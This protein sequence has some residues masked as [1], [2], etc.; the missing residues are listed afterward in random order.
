M[1]D[2]ERDLCCCEYYDLTNNRN[3]ILA[4][5]CNCTDLDEAVDSFLKGQTIAE[6]NK[7]RFQNTM[8]DRLRIPWIG[9][10]RQVAFDSVLPL[11]ILPLMLLTAS[12]SLWW[13][14]FSFSTVGMFLLL[15][16]NFFIKT[17]PRTKFFFVW[18]ITSI[19]LLYFIFEF[20]VIPFLKILIEENVIL[21]VLIFAFI[22]CLYLTKSR[23]DQLTSLSE[24]ESDLILNGKNIE[25][26]YSCK[27]C[28]HRIPDKDHHCVWFDCCITNHNQCS[29]LLS[30]IFAILALLY[31]S[32]LTLTSV[33][34]P[35]EFAKSIL[36]PD[37]CSEVY[38]QF[39]L[40]LS[41]V[42]AIY[43]ILVA[44]LLWL[45]LM[46]QIMLVSLGIPL[47]DWNKL[48]FTSK[49]CLGLNTNRPH[50]KGIINNWSKILCQTS[51][52]YTVLH[53]DV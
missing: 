5:L 10:A 4:C 2:E 23:A 15:I 14:V 51:P 38:Y 12:L 36:L 16:F 42:S 3:H 49:L 1:S 13:T 18:T 19:I 27:I 21:S 50:N 43:S 9:G 39:E 31:S 46:Q 33:C 7:T 53:R 24:S 26:F 25:G 52:K 41:F 6:E 40:G 35:F 32:N 29:F 34:H 11:M 44:I 28:D 45:V 8:R 22:M 48:S 30:L 47:R 20:V 37:D 17:I